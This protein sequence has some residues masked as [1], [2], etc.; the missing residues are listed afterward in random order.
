KKLWI[1]PESIHL[2]SPES[3]MNVVSVEM[4]INENILSVKEYMTFRKMMIDWNAEQV[5]N[6]V[7]KR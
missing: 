1:Y 6:L 7:F 5:N 4:Q 2:K 3:K